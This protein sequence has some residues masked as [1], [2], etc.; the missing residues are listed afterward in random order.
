MLFVCIAKIACKGHENADRTI[1]TQIIHNSGQQHNYNVVWIIQEIRPNKLALLVM[2]VQFSVCCP[3]KCNGFYYR[4][5]L[6]THK[7]GI[8]NNKGMF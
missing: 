3:S 2:A 4:K 5:E 7:T 6:M 8:R 1:V